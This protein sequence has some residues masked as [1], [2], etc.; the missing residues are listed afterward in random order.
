MVLLVARSLEIFM[1]G[2]N[3]FR[4]PSEVPACCSRVAALIAVT[5][6]GTSWRFSA[7]RRAVTTISASPSDAAAPVDEDVSAWA[8]GICSDAAMKTAAAITLAGK[9]V[10]VLLMFAP[11]IG[12][13]SLGTAFVF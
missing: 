9:L 5:A 11:R 13:S 1:F 10:L 3:L 4:S 6:T 7:R 8:G 2:T 12:R